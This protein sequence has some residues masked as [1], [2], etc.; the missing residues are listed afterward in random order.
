MLQAEFRFTRHGCGPAIDV[1]VSLTAMSAAT[2]SIDAGDFSV[3]R[4]AVAAAMS[5]VAFA[6]ARVEHAQPLA[7]TFTRIVDHSGESDGFA[8][9][10]CAAAAMYHLL[11]VPE[12]APFPGHVLKSAD[13]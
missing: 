2:L 6:Y 12:L 13:D 1:S 8:F 7:V 4:L 9:K 10:T 11:G 3:H 5:G